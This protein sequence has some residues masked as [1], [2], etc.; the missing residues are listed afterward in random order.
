MGLVFLA[1]LNAFSVDV[2]DYELLNILY[3]CLSGFLRART[4]EVGIPTKPAPKQT[5][6]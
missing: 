5:T 1:E 3:T 6:L 2:I 4:E